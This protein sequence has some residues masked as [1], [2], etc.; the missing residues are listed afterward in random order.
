MFGLTSSCVGPDIQLCLPPSHY[1]HLTHFIPSFLMI[2][3]SQYQGSGN[4][5]H[6]WISCGRSLETSVVALLKWCH[7]LS[8]SFHICKMGYARVVLRASEGTRSTWHSAWPRVSAR[9][10]LVFQ[11][12]FTGLKRTRVACPAWK[13]AAHL[14]KPFCTPR[15]AFLA[16]LR[17]QGPQPLPLASDRPLA[18]SDLGFTSEKR[19]SPLPALKP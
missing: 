7:S 11:S 17:E 16:A 1:R 3:Y 14:V 4:S 15:T 13:V 12:P 19:L 18:L 8:L 6:C 2:C 9:Q 10:T 5:V